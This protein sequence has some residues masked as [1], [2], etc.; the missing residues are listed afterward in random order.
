MKIC[1]V[2]LDNYPVLA[3]ARAAGYIG[4]ESVQQTLLA[5]GFAELGWD[6]ATVVKDHGQPDGEVI[7]GIR[8]LTAFRPGGGVPGLRFVHPRMTGILGALRRAD[9]DV[10]YQSCAGVATGYTAWHAQRTGGR[11]VFRVAHDTDCRPGEELIP[12]ARDRAIYRW[13]LRRANLIS[14]QSERQVADLQVHYGLESM[15]FPML[16]QLPEP[17]EL[18]QPRDIDVLWVNNLRDFKRPERMLELAR[19][20]PSVNFTMIGGPCADHEA[21]FERVRAGAESLPNLDF[22]GFVPYH[23]VN[24]YYA[25]AKLF[26]N[27]SDSEGFPNSFLQAWV[28]ETPVISF[29][30][31]DG[32]IAQA[33]LGAVPA[34]LDEMIACVADLLGDTGRLASL[35]AAARRYALGTH[36]P[37]AVAAAHAHAFEALRGDV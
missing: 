33:G 21:L 29:F 32:L 9:A 30:D 34:N 18:E 37:T 11:F 2:G 27:T 36:A 16:V 17:A 26:V 4:G 24:P 1:F 3:R 15:I 7:D 6:V 10:Y 5:R 19:R 8:V 12:Y 13:G 28:R 31:P 35:G 20:V 25:R 23:E 22:L 14:A